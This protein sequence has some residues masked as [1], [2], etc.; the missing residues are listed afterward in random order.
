MFVLRTLSAS[1][2]P[3]SLLLAGCNGGTSTATEAGG[4][5][6]EVP[7]TSVPANDNDIAAGSDNSDH[8]DDG[9]AVND[10]TPVDQDSGS[11]GAPFPALG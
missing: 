11:G 4:G 9:D 1:S 5:N 6:A 7:G 3:L 2:L 8:A 10:N